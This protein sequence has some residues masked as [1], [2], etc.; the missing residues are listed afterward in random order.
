MAG[1]I[2]RAREEG[3]QRGMEQ[4]MQRGMEHGR[5]EGSARC[6]SA[7][8]GGGSAAFGA[9]LDLDERVPRRA[10]TLRPHACRRTP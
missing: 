9:S 8:S 2:Q 4:G 1:V 6:W 7:C 10:C 5:V 3:V